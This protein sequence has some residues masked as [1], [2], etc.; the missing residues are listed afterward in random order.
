MNA[1]DKYQQAVRHA[2]EATFKMFGCHAPYG[3]D[4][5]EHSFWLDE[6]DCYMMQSLQLE[7]QKKR[8]DKLLVQLTAL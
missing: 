6:F 3:V 1:I 4:S 8:L 5:K 7:Q 2:N